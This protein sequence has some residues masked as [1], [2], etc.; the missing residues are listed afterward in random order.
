MCGK[1]TA[2]VGL[3][4]EPHQPSPPWPLRPC[5][6]GARLVQFRL[7]SRLVGMKG[8]MFVRQGFQFIEHDGHVA[9]HADLIALGMVGLG[10]RFLL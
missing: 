10:P 6:F 7:K 2:V 5:Q 8:S 3:S 9:R 1:L 4:L